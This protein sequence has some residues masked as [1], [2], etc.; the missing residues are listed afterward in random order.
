KKL[1]V[2]T[3]VEGGSY[4]GYET[5]VALTFT[6]EE[7]VCGVDIDGPSNLVTFLETIPP[8]WERKAFVRRLGGDLDDEVG[9]QSLIA[10]SPL[11]LADRVKKPLLI[12]QGANDPRVKQ[13]ESDQFVNVL[14]KNNI[15]VTY[16]LYPDEGHGITKVY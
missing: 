6:P 7:F 1:K 4:G 12:I 9:R 10:R 5:L 13:R 3:S 2:V 15:P 8:Y 11:F 16:V 14:R